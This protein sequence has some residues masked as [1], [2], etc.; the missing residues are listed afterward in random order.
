VT[1][2]LVQGSAAAKRLKN[3]ALSYKQC[4]VLK[5]VRQTDRQSCYR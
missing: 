2:T 3:T 4:G 1:F 5:C